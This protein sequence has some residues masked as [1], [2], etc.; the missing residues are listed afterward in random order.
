[1]YDL[2]ASVVMITVGVLYD[3]NMTSESLKNEILLTII[4]YMKLQSQFL[5]LFI[6]MVVSLTPHWVTRTPLAYYARFQN[7]QFI[8]F[9]FYHTKAAEF[10]LCTTTPTFYH[11]LYQI[12][13][14]H[15]KVCVIRKELKQ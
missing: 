5:K 3:S 11:I 9:S 13:H 1:M 8:Q 7:S 12:T 14:T 2:M 15:F 4:L 6:G 10:Y